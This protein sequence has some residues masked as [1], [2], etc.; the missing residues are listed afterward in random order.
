MVTGWRLSASYCGHLSLNSTGPTQTP[1]PTRTNSLTS[2]MRGSRR[3]PRRCSRPATAH[4]ACSAG[5]QSPRTFVWHARFSSWG[6]PLGMRA[7]TWLSV[8][9]YLVTRQ[10]GQQS[11]RLNIL[12]L[13]KIKALMDYGVPIRSALHY[14]KNSPRTCMCIT[15]G[16]LA[17]ICTSSTDGHQLSAWHRLEALIGSP[18][19]IWL[20]LHIA[21]RVL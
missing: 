15:T 19:P 1:T 6:C 12:C 20:M 3:T 13:H 2:G 17:A 8:E 18:I 10:L 5:R 7:C 14:A 21:S 11:G 9:H 4:A 16:W